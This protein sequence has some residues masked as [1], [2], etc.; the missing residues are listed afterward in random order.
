MRT[1]LMTVVA[2]LLLLGFGI[3]LGAGPL[4]GDGDQLRRE[5]A[6]QRA[7]LADRDARLDR[8]ASEAKLATAYTDATASRVLAG[9]LAGRRIALV[10]LPG[11]DAPTVKRLEI[12]LKA[13][14]APVTARVAIA[15]QLLDADAQGL[16]DALS[17]QMVTESTGLVVPAGAGGY[18][19]TGALLGRAVGV[20]P[21]ARVASAPPDPT[22][23]A[24]RSGLDAAEL[25]TSSTVIARAALAVVV[26]PPTTPA[27]RAGALAEV[28]T[29]LA[30]QVPTVVAG[31]GST[32]L[33]GGVL[34]LLRGE[35]PT[36]LS[37]VDSVETSA[38]G[39]ATVLAVAG[40][41]RGRTG[42]YG[43]LGTVDGPVPPVS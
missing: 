17:S 4:Q 2:A 1:R 9:R 38:G 11:S 30:G 40:L 24:I 23:A 29:G 31:P 37:T 27:A 36:G 32:A 19:R 10:T 18:L 15:D 20:P 25:V 16:V 13:A 42:D 3:A 14:G 22:S 35:D 6:A 33:D 28:L 7:A 21:A 43:T 8:L 5:S 34:A 26:L 39:V 41:T 12:L